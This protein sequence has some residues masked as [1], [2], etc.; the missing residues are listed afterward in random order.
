MLIDTH[1][2]L[3]DDKFD[4]DRFALIGALPARGVAAYIECASDMD[5]AVRAAA[6]SDEYH[7]VYAAVGIHPHDA[8]AWEGAYAAE[9]RSLAKRRKVV[10]IGEIGLDYHYDFSPR[11]AQRDVFRRQLELAG[12][13][14]MPV[15][16]HS[17]E[18]TEDTLGILRE[19]SGVTGVM[20]SFS[21]S[22][23]TMRLLVDMGFYIS[24]GG[25]VTFKNAKKP[26]E[27]ARRT[28]IERLLIETDSPYM[29]PVPHRGERN[30]PEYV[31]L[32]AEKVA[33]LRG[34]DCGEIEAATARNAIDFFK[35]EIS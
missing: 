3:L 10:A 35:L 16:V 18:A 30:S 14:G 4:E 8:R 27:S 6:L 13:L 22:A 17:R 7:G 5:T 32:V 12:G 15:I 24:F 33:E 23:E 26:V 31:R 2:H 20:H 9:L 34:V 21:G 25:M 29:A 11:E 1:A 19:F 28:P